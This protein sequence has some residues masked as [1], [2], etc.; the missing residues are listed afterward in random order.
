MLTLLLYYC[1]TKNST[2]ICDLST[3]NGISFDTSHWAHLWSL[4][5]STKGGERRLGRMMNHRR[6][7]QMN[8]ERI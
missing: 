6:T 7:L 2:D 1:Y 5:Q 3:G 8:Q 4:L